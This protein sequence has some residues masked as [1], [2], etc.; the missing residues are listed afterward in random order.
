[1]LV[2]SSLLVR[3]LIVGLRVDCCVVLAGSPAAC[4]ACSYMQSSR[5]GMQLQVSARKRAKISPCWDITAGLMCLTFTDSGR[6]PVCTA[7]LMDPMR[8]P[9]DRPAGVPGV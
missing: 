2:A 7:H 4:L 8:L 5:G 6:Y 3:M 1:M 9:A